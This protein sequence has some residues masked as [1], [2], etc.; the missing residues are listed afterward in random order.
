M[1]LIGNLL[2]QKFQVFTEVVLLKLG[3]NL[4]FK[5]ISMGC[6]E[7]KTEINNPDGVGE[8]LKLITMISEIGNL[9]NNNLIHLLSNHQECSDMEMICS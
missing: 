8:L 3:G 9:M 1:V 4:I 2:T 5:E 6:S 7:M